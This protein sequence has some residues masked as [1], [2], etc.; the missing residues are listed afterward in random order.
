MAVRELDGREKGDT[1]QEGS[2]TGEKIKTKAQRE[3]NVDATNT[4][5]KRLKEEN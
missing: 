2:A 5:Y 4:M 3:T 1:I